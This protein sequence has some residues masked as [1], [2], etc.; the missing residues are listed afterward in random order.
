MIE[1]LIRKLNA[2]DMIR[3]AEAEALIAAMKERRT[4]R[5]RK[6]IVPQGTEITFSTLLLDGMVCRYKDLSNGERQISALHVPGDFVDLHSFSLKRLDHSIATMTPCEVALFPHTELKRITEELPHLTRMLW[7]L[8]NIDA[9]LHREWEVSLGRRTAAARLAHLFCELHSRL[10]IVGLADANGYE[11]KLTQVDLAEC[12]GLTAVHVNRSLRQLRE[13][14]LVE[15]RE[16]RVRILDRAGL[17]EIAEFRPDYLYL[18][19]RER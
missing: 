2:H 13:K 17:A 15:V 14:G 1:P 12:V 7:L 4:Y 8:T 3:P 19:R 10:E 9:A 6:V 18:E 11:F 16:K 5:A